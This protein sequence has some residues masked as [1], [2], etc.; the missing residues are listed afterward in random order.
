MLAIL[1][2]TRLLKVDNLLYFHFFS[3]LAFSV[4]MLG[5]PAKS[6]SRRTL[7][8]TL[9]S[10]ILALLILTRLRRNG[11]RMALNSRQSWREGLHLVAKLSQLGCQGWHPSDVRGW[12]IWHVNVGPC[13]CRLSALGLFTLI[14]QLR[15][16][17]C[18]Y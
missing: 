8:G 13:P 4:S 12:S 18:I 14:V 10:C 3:Q 2:I 1:L 11:T 15:L 9:W 17:P 16:V 5:V 7:S 6:V